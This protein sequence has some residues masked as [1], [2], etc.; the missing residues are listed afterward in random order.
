M[1]GSLSKSLRGRLAV[2]FLVISILLLVLNFAIWGLDRPLL[3]ILTE[4][5]MVMAAAG[6]VTGVL[7]GIPGLVVCP[8]YGVLNE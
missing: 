3:R 1:F 2:L 4:T 6:M 8:S 5:V 7:F